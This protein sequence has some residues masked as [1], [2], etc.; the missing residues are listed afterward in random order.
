MPVDG[1]ALS[2]LT[3]VPRYVI[4]GLL[5][6][7]RGHVSRLH[8]A[9]V[10]WRVTDEGDYCMRGLC[11]A[12]CSPN[13]SDRSVVGLPLACTRYMSRK[14]ESAEMEIWTL[15][16]LLLHVVFQ[17]MYCRCNDGF[18]G[19]N[20]ARATVVSCLWIRAATHPHTPTHLVVTADPSMFTEPA[21]QWT[22]RNAQGGAHKSLL[23]VVFPCLR[24][25]LSDRAHGK[26]HAC[27]ERIA[28][29]GG[30]HQKRNYLVHGVNKYPCEV[31][32]STRKAC[33]L[34]LEANSSRYKCSNSI[35]H[36]LRYIVRTCAVSTCTWKVM[37][38][39]SPQAT[40]ASYLA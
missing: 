13:L 3:L 6:S 33:C 8:L 28:Y 30:V 15:L 39:P 31:L 2:Y 1:T 5:H 32:G 26:V 20:Q 16:L 38:P 37:K 29:C 24:D 25:S 14:P 12:A 4:I 7:G 18:I 21:N 9:G 40:I 34:L 19:L 35:L 27:R 23:C 11:H 36:A 17:D 22:T 10:Q